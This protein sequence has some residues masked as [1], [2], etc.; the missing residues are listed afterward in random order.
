MAQSCWYLIASTLYS[1]YHSHRSH[2][3]ANSKTS[4]RAAHPAGH[5]TRKS[6]TQGSK[7]Q[8]KLQAP[9]AA[10][11]KDH[12]P[13]CLSWRRNCSVSRSVSRA[14]G[15]CLNYFRKQKH[16]IKFGEQICQKYKRKSSSKARTP[17]G[18]RNSPACLEHLIDPQQCWY[19]QPD[20]LKHL[21]HKN[22]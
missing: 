22:A 5:P 15:K 3:Q 12:C 11:D 18:F 16:L 7:L 19:F 21:F 14:S 6:L 10:V 8:S 9:V 1:R 17:S 20:S 2:C 13:I 4:T